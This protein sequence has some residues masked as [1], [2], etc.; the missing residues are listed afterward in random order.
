MR[1]YVCFEGTVVGWEQHES[2]YIF[3]NET[4][5][6]VVKVLKIGEELRHGRPVPGQT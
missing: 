4:A 1:V 5:E 2:S 6:G 3:L